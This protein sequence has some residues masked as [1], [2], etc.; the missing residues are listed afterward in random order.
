MIRRHTRLVLDQLEWSSVA[1]RESR[2]LSG[3]SRRRLARREHHY[4]SRWIDVI[5]RFQP[6]LEEAEQQ[7]VAYGI[8]GLLNSVVHWPRAA[9]ELDDAV[10]LVARMALDSL[11][12]VGPQ[13]TPS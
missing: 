8:V 12:S 11:R 13:V 5:A 3:E 1:V 7:A 6:E 2:S 4:M 10:E 9:R